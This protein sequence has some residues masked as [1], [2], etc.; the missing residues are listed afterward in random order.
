VGR[1]RISARVV[2]PAQLVE[3]LEEEE[4]TDLGERPAEVGRRQPAHER[5]QAGRLNR[6]QALLLEEQKGRARQRRARTRTGRSFHYAIPG[7]RRN[8]LG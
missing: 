5:R 3:P 2:E 4:L 7:L 6:R 1:F 8:R